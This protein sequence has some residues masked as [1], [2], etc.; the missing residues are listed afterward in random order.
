MDFQTLLDADLIFEP[1]WLHHI[2]LLQ[3][4]LHNSA[5]KTNPSHG[6]LVLPSNTPWYGMLVFHEVESI[7]SAKLLTPRMGSLAHC[8]S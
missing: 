2:P 8:H 5:W 1:L 6:L 7:E 3:F 4:P